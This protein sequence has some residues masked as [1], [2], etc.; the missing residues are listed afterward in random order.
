MK[1]QIFIIIMICSL[2]ELVS[3]EN[4]L[5]Y[6]N[7]GTTSSV[8]DIDVGI[9]GTSFEYTNIND[10]PVMH[11]AINGLSTIKYYNDCLYFFPGTA[12][13]FTKS[14]TL[15]RY[16]C[17]TGNL[18]SVCSDPLCTHDSPDCPFFGFTT[19]FY[20]YNNTVYYRRAYSYANYDA[21]NVYKDTLEWSGFVSYNMDSSQMKVYN[22]FDS[23]D[24]FEYGK[25]IYV[26]NYCF[27]YDYIYS[28]ESDKEIFAICRMDLNTGESVILG[29]KNN[30][31]SESDPNMLSQMFL[32]TLDSRIY[33]T[34]GKTIYSTD[35][36][37]NDKT[38]HAKGLFL[39]D[40]CTDGEYIYYSA[41]QKNNNDMFISI[42]R[43]NFDGS[44][45]IDIGITANKWFGYFI[46]EN[47]IYYTVPDEKIIG[48][49]KVS[50]Y[51]GTDIILN[52]SE[53][54]RCRHDGSNDESVY[55]FDN[56]M[57]NYR[58][59]DICAAGNYIYGLYS[60]W[61]DSDNDGT[62]E[63]GDQYQSSDD[64]HYNIMRINI[65]TAVI[66]YIKAVS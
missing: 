15:M 14:I 21:N 1:R 12:N 27:Y 18:T 36:D 23:L 31:F 17:K 32:F 20:L 3:C 19:I 42:H 33:F 58:L 57:A 53:I 55:K 28:D 16:D 64:N 48:K 65:E 40:V 13:P 9:N 29:G 51:S 54:R 52:N 66:H 50:G 39:D 63:D 5:N 8:K 26:E 49:N 61:T 37:M 34:D 25:Q 35:Y 56:D 2:M 24:Y 44:S 38:E 45:D 30:Q 62:F 47:Y 41:A 4:N 10:V 46:T 59:T 43:M 60:Y 6:L 11:N 22:Q 7:A